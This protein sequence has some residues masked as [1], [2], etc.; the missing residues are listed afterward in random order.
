MVVE[1]NLMAKEAAKLSVG[2]Y[3]QHRYVAVYESA[4]TM[5]LL[6]IRVDDHAQEAHMASLRVQLSRIS[7]KKLEAELISYEQ[8]RD[9]QRSLTHGAGSS[10]QMWHTRTHGNSQ[11]LMCYACHG[12]GH[13]WQCCRET[14]TQKGRD[15]LLSHN[16]R[17]D[18]GFRL[19]KRR[20][21]EYFGAPRQGIEPTR[22]GPGHGSGY[23]GKASGLGYG[24][25]QERKSEQQQPKAKAE[26][27]GEKTA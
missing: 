8:G 21:H 2:G 23:R 14:L 16:I 22:N 15:K 20:P 24:R 9:I 17:V 18:Q 1:L 25:G 6:N 27:P 13:S 26:A 19:R 12:V 5:R 4:H 10:S 7:V 3:N 11:P